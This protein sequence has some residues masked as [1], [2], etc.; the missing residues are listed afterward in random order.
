MGQERGAI[1]EG[2]GV[3]GVGHDHVERRR[4]SSGRARR[5]APFGE[6]HVPLVVMRVEALLELGESR[7]VAVD[8]EDPDRVRHVVHLWRER[9]Q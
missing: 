8:D 6:V 4:R 7:G 9:G 2:L 5:S 1:G 3:D